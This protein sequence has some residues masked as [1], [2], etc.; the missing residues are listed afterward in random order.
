MAGP[1]RHRKD[2]PW[3]SP[4]ASRPHG[5]GAAY[6]LRAPPMSS[7]CCSK[8]ATL[9]SWGD[10]IR[11]IC[12]SLTSWASC[13]ST[14]PAASC[15][16]TCAPRATSG[17]ASSSPGL[18][19]VGQGARRRRE[20]HDRSAGPA[21]PPRDGHHD[22]G[23]R[24]SKVAVSWCAHGAIYASGEARGMPAFRKVLREDWLTELDWA[25]PLLEALDRLRRPLFGFRMDGSCSDV[26]KGKV[27]AAPTVHG[28]RKVSARTSR[29]CSDVSQAC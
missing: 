17:P 26:R 10:C 12:S 28:P 7:D 13:L 21:R 18:L 2:A 23:K 3:P 15:S 4:S 24:A 20:A 11:S 14:A 25:R 16:S 27:L 19:R 9:A 8:P 29:L 1:D 6:S 22:Q 5:N